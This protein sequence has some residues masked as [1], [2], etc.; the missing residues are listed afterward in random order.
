MFRSVLR[1]QKA[2]QF[3]IRSLA[4]ATTE[5]AP[6]LKKFQVYRWNP[7]TPEV[8]PKMQTYEVD[9]NKCGPMVLDAL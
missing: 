2:A 4:T 5:K 9:L 3:S 8:Q 6:R 1:Q 7:D